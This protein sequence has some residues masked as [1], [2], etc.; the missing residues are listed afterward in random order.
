MNPSSL[1]S[2]PLVLTF[3][4]LPPRI[5]TMLIIRTMLVIARISMGLYTFPKEL[6]KI[7]AVLPKE[8]QHTGVSPSVVVCQKSFVANNSF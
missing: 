3:M 1:A 7:H 2:E 8:L 6:S 5:R 4:L